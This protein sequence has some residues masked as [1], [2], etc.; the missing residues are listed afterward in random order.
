VLRRALLCFALLATS[1]GAG[2]R[3][4][5]PDLTAGPRGREPAQ[6]FEFTCTYA[7]GKNKK[8]APAAARRLCAARRSESV[9]ARPTGDGG[10]R[11]R[12]RFRDTRGHRLDLYLYRQGGR[13][14]RGAIL[15]EHKRG[16]D[17]IEVEPDRGW[18]AV[19]HLSVRRR[20]A[21]GRYALTF[22]ALRIGGA[23]SVGTR[24][25]APTKTKAPP[26]RLRP[27]EPR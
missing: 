12:I 22:G 24:P 17:L 9:V 15:V 2:A 5:N 18:I 10:L 6:G 25:E 8:Q 27:E 3:R 13:V 21:V 23:F 4:I 7:P 1:C 26:G 19:D 20:A 16:G 11:V 14:L